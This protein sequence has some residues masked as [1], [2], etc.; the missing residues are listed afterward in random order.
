MWGSRWICCWVKQEKGLNWVEEVEQYDERVMLGC[1]DDLGLD[2]KSLRR[3][4]SPNGF[5]AIAT[6]V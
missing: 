2:A 6:E 5:F 4:E 3:I 1:G